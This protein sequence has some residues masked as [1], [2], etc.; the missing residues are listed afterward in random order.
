MFTPGTYFGSTLAVASSMRRIG[1]CARIA[2]ARHTSCRC[3]T[4]RFPPPSLTWCSKPPEKS[5]TVDFN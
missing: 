5:S 1:L 2:L 3:P 4:L